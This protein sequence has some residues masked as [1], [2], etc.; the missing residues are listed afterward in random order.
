MI[1]SRRKMGVCRDWVNVLFCD[2][3]ACDPHDDGQPTLRIVP[4][5]WDAQEIRRMAKREG[6]ARRLTAKRRYV[7]LCPEC[8]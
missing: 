6:W 4:R 7:D 2:V 8:R 3:P 5:V 1:N